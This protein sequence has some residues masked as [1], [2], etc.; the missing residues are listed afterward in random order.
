LRLDFAS[1]IA[2]ISFSFGFRAQH[3]LLLNVL[4][5]VI[6]ILLLAIFQPLYVVL[7][8]VLF[9]AGMAAALA[10]IILKALKSSLWSSQAGWADVFLG[11]GFGLLGLLLIIFLVTKVIKYRKKMKFRVR[12]IG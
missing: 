6:A 9:L 5:L 4:P 7:W 12:S 11:A 3:I 10:G 2:E 8:Y 1:R